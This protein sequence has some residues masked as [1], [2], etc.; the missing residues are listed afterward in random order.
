MFSPI[1]RRERDSSH[2]HYIVENYEVLCHVSLEHYEYENMF[3]EGTG[4]LIIDHEYGIVYGCRSDRTDEV[5]FVRFCS[6]MGYTP[7]LF[8]ARDQD[9]I[10][11]YHTNVVMGIGQGYVLI[12]R[13]AVEDS[14]WRKLI[15]YFKQTE[16]LI[17]NISHTQMRSFLANS[18][19]IHNEDDEPYIVMSDTAY[20]VLKQEQKKE[21]NRFGN[22][23][24]SDIS[25]IERIG[26]GSV[27]CMI[28]ENYLN[29][30]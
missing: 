7:V 1:R 6:L 3:V 4:S 10:P 27:K 15:F 18:A 2:I 9:G 16:K 29:M 13:S 12:N 19:Y 21:L 28:T 20:G 11:V 22:I 30:R 24:H 8:D 25:T 17:I 26:G 5:P 14:D 23:I